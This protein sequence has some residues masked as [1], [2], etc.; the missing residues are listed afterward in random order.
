MLVV[1]VVAAAVFGLLAG[2]GRAAFLWRQRRVDARMYGLEGAGCLL[3]APAGVQIV[4]SGGVACHEATKSRGEPPLPSR[5]ARGVM[6][7]R[8]DRCRIVLARKD[9]S[10]PS[11]EMEFPWDDVEHVELSEARA[12]FRP[13]AD[14]NVTMRSGTL[15]RLLVGASVERIG[16]VL[17]EVGVRVSRP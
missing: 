14:L 3:A 13:A 16:R 2:C 12:L 10:T 5:S 1:A 8:Q 4:P 7:L 6:E 17:Y 15:Y 9:Q 11:G